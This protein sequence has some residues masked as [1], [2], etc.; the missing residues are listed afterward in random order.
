[1]NHEIG[2][3]IT[4][5]TVI[6]IMSTR[7]GWTIN[8]TI[9]RLSKLSLYEKLCDPETSLWVDN[10]NDIADLFDKELNGEVLTLSD[11]I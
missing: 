1:M 6:E 5:Q 3:K 9:S 8:E 7:H 4:I 11:F 2:A 10:P